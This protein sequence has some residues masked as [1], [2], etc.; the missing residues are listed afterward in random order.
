M[1]TTKNNTRHQWVGYLPEFGYCLLRDIETET[2][3]LWTPS[4]INPGDSILFDNHVLSFVRE[5]SNAYR[6]VDDEYNR[7]NYPDEI[8]RIYVD[9]APA[10]VSTREL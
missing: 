8:G 9:I 7:T 3:E 1:I 6:A 2:L 4:D 5:V 10:Y